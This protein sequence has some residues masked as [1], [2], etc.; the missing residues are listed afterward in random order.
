[1]SNKLIVAALAASLTLLGGSAYAGRLTDGALGAGAG[2][3]VGGPVGAVAGGVIGYS[4][5]P[6]ISCGMRGGCRHHHR[7]HR[8]VR[9]YR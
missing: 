2:A 1:M 8:H 4:A 9:H 5:G 3:L 6:A 7:N